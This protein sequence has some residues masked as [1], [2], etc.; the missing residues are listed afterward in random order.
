MVKNK[1]NAIPEEICTL[2]LNKLSS[3]EKEKDIKIIFCAEAGS[4]AW[5]IPSIDSDY[6]IRFVFMR[7]PKDYLYLSG[8]AEEITINDGVFDIYGVDIKKALHLI[9]INEPGI[10]G[11][12]VSPI[13]YIQENEWA[14][15]SEL[16]HQHMNQYAVARRLYGM[17]KL[18]Y[19]SYIRGYN[20]V[21]IK[22]Y[23][24]CIRHLLLA[25]FLLDHP[26][27]SNLPYDITKLAAQYMP[28]ELYTALMQIVDM[29]KESADFAKIGRDYSLDDF[30][31][32]QMSILEQKIYPHLSAIEASKNNDAPLNEYFYKL[33]SDKILA[34]A[35]I[36]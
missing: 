7:Q 2:I 13:I 27:Y 25:H 14:D 5:G 19:V 22:K 9:S 31:F 16:I 15:L 33:V 6:D 34:R 11:W 28:G 3:I 8:L 18:T 30:A 26:D 4:R 10:F 12:R 35:N 23:V 21:P 36:I 24:Y 1:N 32:D 29:K 20:N 17:A